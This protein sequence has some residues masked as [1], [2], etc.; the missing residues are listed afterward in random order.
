MSNICKTVTLRT[1]KIKKGTQLSFYLDYYPGYRDESTMKVQR[2][3]SLGIYIFAK[4]KNQRERDYNE[5]M[6]EKAEALRCRRYESIVNERYDF[7]DRERMKGDF[8]AYFKQKA[9]KKNCKWQ[10]AY[11]HFARFCNNKC[12]FDEIN[13]DFCNRFREYLMTAPQTIHTEHKLHINSVSGYWSTFRAVLHT[14]YREHKI[15]ENPNGFLERIDTIP[16]EKEHLSQPELVSL[17]NTDCKEPV[18]KKAFLFSCLTGLRKSDVKA[19][20]W[21]KIQPYGDGGMYITVRMQKTQQLVNNPVSEEALE[22]IGFYDGE[23][24]P[25]VKVFPDFKDKMTGTTMKNWL[26]AAGIT[27][28]ITFHCGRHTFGSLQVDAGTGIY[29]VQH[30]LGHKNVETT[31]IYA[32]MA[33]ESKPESV[34]R[35]TL[36]PKITLQL[37]VVGQG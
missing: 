35:I 19:L 21:K 15:M 13:V 14:A 32:N 18:L 9:D 28:H 6:T 24:E 27:K 10:H 16:T 1:R 30:M 3:E 33:D 12:R 8:L 22:L 34:N 37:K 4:P 20:T 31:Q 2:H 11:K 26:K 25:D 17:A 36:K 7:F 5:R 29:T 23:H